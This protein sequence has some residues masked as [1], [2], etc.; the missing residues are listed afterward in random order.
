MLPPDIR[1]QAEILERDFPAREKPRLNPARQEIRECLSSTGWRLLITTAL[2]PVVREWR[3]ALIWNGDLEKEDRVALQRAMAMV[4]AAI[5]SGYQKSEIPI[6]HWLSQEF[7]ASN[8][9]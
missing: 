3:N 5:R 6:P 7:E 1:A 4:Y 8:E 2:L 9:P